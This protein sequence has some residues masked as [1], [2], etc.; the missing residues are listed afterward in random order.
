MCNCPERGSLQ[1]SGSWAPNSGPRKESVL[2]REDW[3]R[4]ILTKPELEKSMSSVTSHRTVLEGGRGGW[5]SKTEGLWKL[6]QG[7]ECWPQNLLLGVTRCLLDVRNCA[8]ENCSHY[9]AAWGRESCEPLWKSSPLPHNGQGDPLQL[10]WSISVSF[11]SQKWA[12][13]RKCLT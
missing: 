3:G 10:L 9:S 8:P 12:R 11:H 13:K 1:I 6:H 5:S 2:L 4:K 7:L